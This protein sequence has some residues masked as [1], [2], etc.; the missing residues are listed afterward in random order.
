MPCN[1][2]SEGGEPQLG[3]KYLSASATSAASYFVRDDGSVDRYT[4]P[5]REMLSMAA[6]QRERSNVPAKY[7]QVSAHNYASYLVRD[8]G[9]VDRTTGKGQVSLTMTPTDEEPEKEGGCVVM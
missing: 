8:D 2:K 3:M 9:L 5:S 1:A 4:G 7:V 6:P